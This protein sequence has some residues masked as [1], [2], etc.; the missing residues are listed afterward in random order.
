FYGKQ[1]TWDLVMRAFLSHCPVPRKT[2]IYVQDGDK[3]VGIG[4]NVRLEAFVQGI[5]PAHGKVEVRYR[6]RRTQDYPLGQDRDNKIRFGRTIENI[7]VSF[8][9]VIYLNDAVSE[10]YR[11]TAIPRPTVA[12]IECEQQYPAYTHIKPAKRSLGDLSLLA[13]ST[14][15]LSVTATKPLKTASGKLVGLDGDFPMQISAANPKLISGQ[16]NIP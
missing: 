2:R 13:G 6:T 5:I 3:I 10:S 16:F 15:K 1:T 14:L 9:Y 7:Q 12:S 4:D 11:V 8:T